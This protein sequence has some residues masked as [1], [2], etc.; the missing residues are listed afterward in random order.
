MFAQV[1][2]AGALDREVRA[3]GI[4]V[5]TICPAGVHTEFAIGAGRTEG[6]P[7]LD[8]YLHPVSPWVL[9]PGMA[10]RHWT[11]TSSPKTSRTRSPSCCSSRAGFGPPNGSCGVWDKAVEDRDPCLRLHAT[12]RV[13]GG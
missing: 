6:D 9:P 3:E 8:D 10:P 11:T 4:R 2:L 5:T 1:G 13:R 7:S 12:R